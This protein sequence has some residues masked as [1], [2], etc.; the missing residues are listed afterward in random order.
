MRTVERRSLAAEDR[1]LARQI[2]TKLR[3]ARHTAG[4]TQQQVAAGRYT[5]AYVSALENGLIKPSMAALRFLAVRLGTTP[6]ELLAESDTRWARLDAELHLAAGDWQA[7]ADGYQVLLDDEPQ[8]A[9]RGR[10]LLGMAES[11]IRLGRGAE[12][13]A[14]ASE[15]GELLGRSSLIRDTR[16]ARYWLAA[17]HHQSDNASEARRLFEQLL[18]DDTEANPLGPDF[19]VRILIS[20][21]SVLTHAGEPKRGL[22]LLE[23][24][25]GI[26]ADLDDRR[27]GALLHSLALGYRAT[28]D[29]EGAIRT[30]LQSL[31]LYESAEAVVEMAGI[32]NELALIYVGL[33]N[34]AEAR[35]HAASARTQFERISQDFG[36][37]HV[38]DTEGQIAL[39]AGDAKNA[40]E[41]ATVA[42]EL[43]RRSGNQKA[44]IS[45]LLTQ[46]RA[47]RLRRDTAQA[48][49]VLEA[50]ADLARSGPKPRLREILSEWS[51]LMADTGDVARAYELSREALA[52]V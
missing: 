29:M 45:G 52:L 23:E 44:E 36:L 24:A 38:S 34:L 27:R 21:A 40:A 17:G 28:G 7:A 31:A 19:R 20:L 46:A 1:D 35:R 41:R 39:A 51:E 47:H 10:V 8:G 5:K 13:V 18:A 14:I 3:T 30:G 50:A 6:S 26:G 4:L 48:A 33:G 2:G 16:Q 9:E 25:R 32:E 37:A 11:L 15:A 43:A 12:A 42:V 49:A 22:A